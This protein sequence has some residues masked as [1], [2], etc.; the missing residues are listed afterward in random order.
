MTKKK[1]RRVRTRPGVRP[2]KRPIATER[3]A[4]SS[5]EEQMPQAEG[6]GI[7]DAPAGFRDPATL[8]AEEDTKSG[9]TERRRGLFGGLR[10]QAQQSPYPPLGVSLARGLIAVGS[11]ASILIVAFLSMVG[12]WGLFAVLG[13]EPSPRFIAILMSLAPVHVFFDANAVLVASTDAGTGEVIGMVVGTALLRSVTFGLLAILIVEALRSGRPNVRAAIR[14]LPRVGGVLWAV[15]AAEIGIVLVIPFLLQGLG[16]SG[17][18]SLAIPLVLVFGLHFLVMAPAI[19]AGERSSPRETLLRSVRA[20]RLPGL[21]HFALAG[22]YFAFILWTFAITPASA[23]TS[24]TPSFG[25]WAITLLL[26][27]VHIGVLGA[28]TFRWLAVRDRIPAGP[29]PRRSPRG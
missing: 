29:S 4:P 12:T 21:R 9:T 25:I 28:F 19:A 11:S 22:T 7:V 13:T 6:V 5:Q 17:L 18:G 10:Q 16:G 26:T 23:V 1:R 15:Y 27:F 3:P 24:V 2:S 14:S 8:K 20:A